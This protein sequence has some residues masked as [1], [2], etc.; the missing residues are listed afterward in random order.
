MRQAP[1]KTVRRAAFWMVLAGLAI[2]APRVDSW[3]PTRM[4]GIFDPLEF[5]RIERQ[6]SGPSAL[7][8]GGRSDLRTAI[9]ADAIE[10]RDGDRPRRD[11]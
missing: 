6:W 7:G 5:E 3:I 9:R 2:L 10:L 8:P 11:V 4:R 1:R